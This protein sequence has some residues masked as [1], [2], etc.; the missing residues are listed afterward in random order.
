MASSS[1]VK[2]QVLGF[3]STTTRNSN[4]VYYGQRLNFKFGLPLLNLS[5]KS[6]NMGRDCGPVKAKIVGIDLGTSSSAVAAMVDGKPTIITNIP[7]VVAYTQN[8]D[9]LVGKIAER[10]A[11]ENPENTFSSVKRF[12]G[13]NISEVDEESKQVSY[14]VVGGGDDHEN[15][16]VKFECPA[17]VQE[18]G[19]LDSVLSIFG[20]THLG[21]DDFDKRIVD[22]LAESFKRDEGTDLLKDKQ[23]LQCLTE[24]A[25][26]A[27]I[28]LSFSTQA[29]ISLPFI[30]LPFITETLVSPNKR[31]KTTLTRA[32]FE[33]LCSD[34]FDRLT[35]AVENSLRDASLAFDDVDEVILVGGCASI[36]AV[37]EL[38]KKL[39]G[40]D[41]NVTVNPDEKVAFGAAI[42]A[43]ILSGDVVSNTYQYRSLD[44]LTLSLGLETSGG[45]MVK[46]ITRY[47]TFP[48]SVSELFSTIADGQTSIVIHVLQGKVSLWYL[49]SPA[50]G[51]SQVEVKF[52]IDENGIVSVAAFD[53]GTGKKLDITVTGMSID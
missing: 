20:D 6:S 5:K 46:I 12:I 51:V 41:P 15:G 40:K 50:C 33:E 9:T 4:F 23:A 26:K 32:K 17:I 38:V 35:V 2:L 18:V 27:K 47:T 1:A 19:G 53:K 24:A 13:R 21:G 37:Q 36:P 16:N 30:I 49:P 8:G 43:G 48:D 52:D 10:Q 34:L 45:V 14:L 44:R 39:T 11:S 3:P 7:S 31:I 42:Q 29:N 22:W 25:E 28:E